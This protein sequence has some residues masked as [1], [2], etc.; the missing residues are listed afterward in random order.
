MTAPVIGFAGLTHL[1]IV[2]AV[3]TAAKG[4]G[5]VGYDADRARVES[6]RA[7]RMPI[8]EPELDELARN[9]AVRLSYTDDLAALG[10]C[11]VVYI[12]TD[13]PTL[14]RFRR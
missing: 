11:D 4:F 8:V 2:S 6:L 10:R 3:A 5:V 1:G 12:A 14:P 7:G 13:V 9:H